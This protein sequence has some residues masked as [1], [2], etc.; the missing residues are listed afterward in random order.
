MHPDILPTAWACLSSNS[1]LEPPKA[2]PVSA[3]Q[4]MYSKMQNKLAA[5]EGKYQ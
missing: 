4:Q 3:M 1:D 5:Y 2:V